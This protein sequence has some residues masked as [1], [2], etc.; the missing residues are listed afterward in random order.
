MI[1][2]IETKVFGPILFVLTCIVKKAKKKKLCKEDV[3]AS[4]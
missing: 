1:T 2:K 3:E 4:N